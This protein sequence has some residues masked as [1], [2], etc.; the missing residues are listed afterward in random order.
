MRL[1]RLLVCVL[2][3]GCSSSELV[4]SAETE[5]P[6]R[7]RTLLPELLA[8]ETPTEAQAREIENLEILYVSR[9]LATG[10]ALELPVL[11]ALRLVAP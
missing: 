10:G 4:R 3:V 6:D 11:A 8:A 7:F 9:R 1:G 2:L 5:T